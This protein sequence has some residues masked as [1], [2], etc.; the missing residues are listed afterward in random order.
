MLHSRR[1]LE[2]RREQRRESPHGFHVRHIVRHT[3][4]G[5]R[6]WLGN[7]Q[8]SLGE[9]L[10]WLTLPSQVSREVGR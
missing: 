5:L 8:E 3:L 7:T 4:R 10:P 2:Q 1:T 9:L 6:T